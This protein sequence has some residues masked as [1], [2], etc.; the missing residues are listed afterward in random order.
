MNSLIDLEV[1]VSEWANEEA[2]SVGQYLSTEIVY[3]HVRCPLSPTHLVSKA[4]T[5]D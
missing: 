5:V 1:Q 2:H 4:A 3:T